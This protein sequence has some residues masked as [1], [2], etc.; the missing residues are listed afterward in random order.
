MSWTI[1]L[2]QLGLHST[3]TSPRYDAART[4][5]AFVSAGPLRRRSRADWEALCVCER[6]TNCNRH[7]K[8]SQFWANLDFII[9]DYKILF[10][11]LIK[12]RIPLPNGASLLNRDVI[13][14]NSLSILR[15]LILFDNTCKNTSLWPRTNFATYIYTIML[16]NYSLI[17]VIKPWFFYYLRLGLDIII[18]HCVY[19]RNEKIQ[20]RDK[21]LIELIE[22]LN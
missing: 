17:S 15:L 11:I 7:S 9:S 19:N 16:F 4:L 6:T 12:Y 13:S 18:S 3:T 21:Y 20:N 1:W 8:Y 14:L 22:H 10:I 2:G 5:C